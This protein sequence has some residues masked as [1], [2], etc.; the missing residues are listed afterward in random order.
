MPVRVGRGFPE[1]PDERA[2]RDKVGSLG[3]GVEGGSNRT[4]PTQ[5]TVT[6]KTRLMRIQL[7]EPLKKSRGL[8]LVES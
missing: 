8:L 5:S 3:V 4:K 7:Y 6:R 2:G 1:H